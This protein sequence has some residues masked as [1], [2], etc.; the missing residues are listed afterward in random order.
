MRIGKC[1]ATSFSMA[2]INN[3][4]T[5]KSTYRRLIEFE[6][7]AANIYLDLASRFSQEDPKLSSFW[8]DMAMHEKQHA[9]LL[10][11]C[12]LDGLFVADLPNA[13]EIQKLTV[14][15]KRLEK[16]AADPKLTVEDAFRLAI[17]MESSEIS[18]IYCHLTSTL[19]TSMYLLRRK[20]VTLVPAH[21][22]ELIK[23]ARRFGLRDRAIEEL[24][25]L[26]E[27]CS[28]NRRARN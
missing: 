6:E 5:A 27:Q 14:L 9:G 24:S 13:G 2:K 26:N 20:I 23:A 16:R 4:K 12:V 19:H 18:A 17:E 28:P 1:L 7:M 21:I 11:F 15:F 8:L 22:D 3:V 25:R 10:Q